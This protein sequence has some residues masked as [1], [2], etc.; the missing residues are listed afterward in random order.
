M[1]NQQEEEGVM[2][3]LDCPGNAGIDW[4]NEDVFPY[5]PEAMKIGN[6]FRF[7]NWLASRD[8]VLASRVLMNSDEF[9]IVFDR[10][11]SEVGDAS[12]GSVQKTRAG[13]AML[14]LPIPVSKKQAI[15]GAMRLQDQEQGNE[16][17]LEPM[18]HHGG[19]V[20][21]DLPPP[22]PRR[23]Y[24]LGKIRLPVFGYPLTPSNSPASKKDSSLLKVSARLL[25]KE[26]AF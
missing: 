22:H 16:D 19:I 13:K 12:V 2:A 7:Q 11:R 20:N 25:S 4:L 8:P 3:A 18:L 24:A 21:L 17:E 9:K 1:Q 15:P 5:W 14:R 26:K 23:S 10:V 6:V